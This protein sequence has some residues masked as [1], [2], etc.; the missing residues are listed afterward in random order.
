MAAVIPPPSPEAQLTFLSKLQRLLAEG[1]FTATYKFALLVSLADLAVEQGADDG[2]TLPLTTRQIGERFIHLYWR[3]A[4]PYGTGQ[5]RASPGVLVQNNGT[6]AAVI[7]AIANFRARVSISSPQAA[8][9]HPEFRAL[10]T[11]VTNTVS[12]QPLKFMQNFGGGQ[13]E[14]L[15]ERAGA[16]LIRIKPG[17]GFCLRRFQPLIQQ[18]ARSHW[19]GHV[20]GNLRNRNILGAAD[21]LETFLFETPRRS[22]NLLVDGLRKLDGKKCFYCGQN[23]TSMDADHSIDVDHFIPFS[24]YPR[25]L[26]HN[27]VLAHST[28]NR[29]KSDTLAAKPHLEHWLDRIDKHANDITEVG[30]SA[31]LVADVA[32]SSRIASWGYASAFQSAGRG[33]FSANRYEPVNDEYLQLFTPSTIVSNSLD[34]ASP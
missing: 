12:A 29:S 18:V 15:F 25:D 23:L 31:G 32:V 14:F 6:Q 28:C 19:I 33:W 5:P 20:K 4:L 9:V 7:S 8:R 21:D 30:L 1:D 10:L 13:D 27:F 22:L 3:Q 34:Q 17:I 11:T 2:S 16:G 24:Q 26:A